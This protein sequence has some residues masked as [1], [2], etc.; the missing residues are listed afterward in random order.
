MLSERLAQ[1]EASP[2]IITESV[3]ED[4]RARRW[5]AEALTA[6]LGE[7]AV[8]VLVSPTGKFDFTQAGERRYEKKTLAFAEAIGE[9]TRARLPSPCYYLRQLPLKENNLDERGLPSERLLPRSIVM[10]RRLWIASADCVTP[11]HYDGKNNLLTQLRGSKLVRLFPPDE[12]ARMYPYGLRFAI[13]HLSRIDPEE[14]DSALFP[15]FPREREISFPLHA[16]ETLFIPA[17]WWHHVRA[18]DFSVSVNEWWAPRAECYLVENAADY[19]RLKYGKER[20]AKIFAGETEQG[21]AHLFARLA[22]EAAAR[23]LLLAAT[24]FGG[25]AT[26]LLLRFL[27]AADGD[28]SPDG[29]EGSKRGYDEEE[30]A[31]VDNLAAR[32]LLTPHEARQARLWLFLARMAAAEGRT[33]NASELRETTRQ[34]VELLARR[35]ALTD[36]SGRAGV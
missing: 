8:G 32:N 28:A 1:A 17:F 15:E 27:S 11:L 19:L 12:H 13:S 29:V 31:D 24:L 35:A 4:E 14:I 23:G 9:I 25:A 6:I 33:P 36:A 10:E 22:L 2:L 3:S 7:R 26:R 20:L 30:N 5:S 16:G 21:R 34:L 18:C